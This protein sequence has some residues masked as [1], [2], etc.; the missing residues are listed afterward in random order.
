M[1]AALNV[2]SSREDLALLGD[3]WKTFVLDSDYEQ[4]ELRNRLERGVMT[5]FRLRNRMILQLLSQ[6]TFI[7]MFAARGILEWAF[8]FRFS[9][10]V[11]RLLLLREFSLWKYF[12]M[13]L[14]P[15]E[16]PKEVA[17]LYEDNILVPK[18][19]EV[20]SLRH[21]CRIAIR[22]F[23]RQPIRDSVNKLPLPKKV[24]KKLLLHC[25]PFHDLDCDLKSLQIN[26][27]RFEEFCFLNDPVVLPRVCS[28]EDDDEED[29]LDDW[30]LFETA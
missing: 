8:K 18:V 2:V 20:R 27:S 17:M 14:D 9:S 11:R 28:L 25:L 15:P 13:V 29:D 24:R 7:F 21:S 4:H 30:P 16:W 1:D 26:K 6:P 23:L 22:G 10:A 3:I 5:S 12:D 19:K